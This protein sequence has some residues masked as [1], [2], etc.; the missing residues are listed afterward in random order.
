MTRLTWRSWEHKMLNNLAKALGT[1]GVDQYPSD[2]FDLIWVDPSPY[3][4]LSE[5]G[6]ENCPGLD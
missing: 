4:E 5:I 1:K 3:K 6:H 2:H